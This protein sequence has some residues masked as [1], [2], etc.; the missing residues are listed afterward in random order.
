MGSNS[1]H[2]HNTMKEYFKITTLKSEINPRRGFE[3]LKFKKFKKLKNFQ[4]IFTKHNL[5]VLFL[6]NCKRSNFLLKIYYNY[7][8]SRIVKIA[9]WVIRTT[10]NILWSNLYKRLHKIPVKINFLL[11]GMCDHRKVSSLSWV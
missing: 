5:T 7:N 2:I 11:S 10:Y 4:I 1:I 6:S 9:S 3:F 8:V